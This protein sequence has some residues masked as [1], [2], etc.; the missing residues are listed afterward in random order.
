M[1]ME[2]GEGTR[3]GRSASIWIGAAFFV[4]ILAGLEYGRRAL[5]R[6]A[7]LSLIAGLADF[8]SC[9]VVSW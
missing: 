3:A 9:G 8:A 5:G 4:G 7:V 6:S 2:Y 1:G